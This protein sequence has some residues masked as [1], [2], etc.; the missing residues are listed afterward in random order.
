MTARAAGRP[1]AAC[2]GTDRERSGELS[3]LLTTS[4]SNGV[5]CVE[6][7]LLGPLPDG[8]HGPRAAIMP[9]QPTYRVDDGSWPKPGSGT[10]LP[11]S[12]RVLQTARG[13][14]GTGGDRGDGGDQRE[15][16]ERGWQTGRKAPGRCRSLARLADRGLGFSTVD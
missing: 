6:P 2:R 1:L 10:W 15:R 16:P 4:S 9:L 3:L 11:P 5:G 8:L 13:R 14:A 7:Q 12:L